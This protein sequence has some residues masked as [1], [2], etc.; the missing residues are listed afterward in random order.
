M[1]N[2]THTTAVQNRILPVTD[3]HLILLS[4]ILPCAAF[5]IPCFAGKCKY[6]KLFV[7][8]LPTVNGAD[9]SR[10]T[11]IINR[12]AQSNHT[13]H[14]AVP[15]HKHRETV[16]FADKTESKDFCTAICRREEDAAVFSKSRLLSPIT[17][18]QVPVLIMNLFQ[19]L[20]IKIPDWFCSYK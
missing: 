8:P 15:Q 14:K 9:G 20:S 7:M 1:R 11:A 4:D 2:T 6:R 16:P 12:S 18:Q 17:K 5:S 10:L 3:H 19:V 13:K